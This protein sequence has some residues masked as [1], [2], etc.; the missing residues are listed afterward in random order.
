MQK[1]DRDAVDLAKTALAEAI[2][3][4]RPAVLTRL[5]LALLLA[6]AAE[7]ARAGSDEDLA[8]AVEELIAERGLE[9]AGA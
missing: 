5:G 9:I 3:E 7:A 8:Q 4:A 2:Q 1:I 6:R